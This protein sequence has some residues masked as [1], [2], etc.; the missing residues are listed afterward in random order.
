MKLAKLR[1]QRYLEESSTEEQTAVAQIFESAVSQGFQLGC[2]SN[3]TQ[4]AIHRLVLFGRKGTKRS[5]GLMERIG[6]SGLGFL[7]IIL[8]SG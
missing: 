6:G 5:C 8:S 1:D 2:L 7:R 3:T 4:T